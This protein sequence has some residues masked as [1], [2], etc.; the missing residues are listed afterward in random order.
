MW[1]N[2]YAVCASASPRNDEVADALVFCH[3]ERR[4]LVVIYNVG[5]KKI[6]QWNP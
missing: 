5:L 4:S 6:Q 1:A 3:C 2:C